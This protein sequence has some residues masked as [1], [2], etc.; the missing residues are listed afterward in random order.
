LTTFH[1]LDLL[2]GDIDPAVL[3]VQRQVNA[4]IAQTPHVDVHTPE[5]L[6][7]FRASTA[8]NPGVTVLEPR[9]LEIDGPA[10]AIVRRIAAD[11]RQSDA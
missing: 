9:D 11:A 8:H 6:A 2:V 3:A 7:M 5:G 1:S 4:M 10:A